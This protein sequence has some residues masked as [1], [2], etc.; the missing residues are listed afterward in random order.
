MQ[1]SP[2]PGQERVTTLYPYLAYTEM[3]RWTGKDGFSPLY[4]RQGIYFS[5][6]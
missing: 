6:L 3:C 2:P 5:T 1:W 4:S